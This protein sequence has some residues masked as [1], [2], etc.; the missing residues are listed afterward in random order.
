MP[1]STDVLSAGVRNSLAGV[2]RKNGETSSESNSVD[3]ALASA[4]KL[5][6]VT[7]HTVEYGAADCQR[8][9]T[10]NVLKSKYIV[11][12][13]KVSSYFIKHLTSVSFLP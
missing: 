8:S 13:A 5:A 2:F 10:Q 4:N 1:S 7:K 3:S 6:D 12:D 11:L 9:S